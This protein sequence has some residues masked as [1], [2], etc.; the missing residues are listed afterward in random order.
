MLCRFRK[1]VRLNQGLF[2]KLP[3]YRI[4]GNLYQL[5]KSLYSNTKYSI[6]NGDRKT[7]MF[8]YAR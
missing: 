1:S 6:K 5:I 8:N 2:H 4:D 7:K 3:E